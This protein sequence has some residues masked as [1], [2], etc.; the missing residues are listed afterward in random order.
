MGPGTSTTGRMRPTAPTSWSRG[1]SSST[2]Q[3]DGPARRTPAAGP[4]SP[5]RPHRAGELQGPLADH[6]APGPGPDGRAAPATALGRTA[7][8]PPG[9]GA[10][11]PRAP[12]GAEGP[13]PARA[14]HRLC[15]SRGAGH[16]RPGPDPGH[17]GTPARRV[18][19]GSRPTRSSGRSRGS[20]PPW[21]AILLAEIG[22]IG[23]FTKFSQLRK[24]AGLTSCGCSPGNSQGRPGS[25]SVAGASSAG[26]CITRRWGPPRTVAGRAR[27]AA[28]KAKRRGDR[29]PGS[30]RSSNWRRSSSGHLGRVAE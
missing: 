30:R 20:G 25:R 22:D 16:G 24:L 26:R 15:R 19:S 12:G 14:R 9:L 27:L 28:L 10:R 7:R 6:A 13:P 18:P 17:R 11:R 5:P 3:P 21:R 1:R 8:G 4:V 2:A 23:W 29:S